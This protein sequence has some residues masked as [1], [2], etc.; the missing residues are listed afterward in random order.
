MYPEQLALDHI[1]SWSNEGDVVLDPF[2]GAGT[3]AK[4]SQS[5][6]RQFIGFEIDPEYYAICQRRIEPQGELPL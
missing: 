1:L 6:G 4:M 3:T 5:V 2:M